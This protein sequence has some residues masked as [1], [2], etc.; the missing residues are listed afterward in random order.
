VNFNFPFRF[1]GTVYGVSLIVKK[2]T[3]ETV[4]VPLYKTETLARGIG[5]GA[6]DFCGT[7]PEYAEADCFERAANGTEKGALDFSNAV[8]GSKS[9]GKAEF[10]KA[11]GTEENRGEILN[12]STDLILAEEGIYFY[13]FE[14]YTEGKTFFVKR[15]KGG[16]ADF[17]GGEW[18]LT[19]YDKYP[20]T[21]HPLAGGVIYHIF[22]DRFKKGKTDGKTDG[23]ADELISEKTDENIKRLQSGGTDKNTEVLRNGEVNGNAERLRNGGTDKNAEVLRNGEVNGN[24]EGLQSGEI[25]YE[26]AEFREKNGV[27]TAKKVIDS[28]RIMKEWDDLPAVADPDGVFRAN[29]FFGGNAE[30]VVE[31]LDYIASLGVNVVY[32][33]PIFEAASNHRYDT[34]DYFKIDPLFGD[35]AALKKLVAEAEKR[36]MIVMMD[37]VFNHTGSDSVYFNKEG[38]YD[39]VGAYQSRDSEYYDFYEFTKFPDKYRAW[40]GIEVVPALNKA[41]PKVR[42]LVRAAVRKWISFGIK[43]L[44]LDV[45]DELPKDYIFDIARLVKTLAPDAYLLG[46]VW[47]DA[48]TKVSYGTMRPY[49]LGSQLDSVMNYP[50]KEAILSFVKHNDKERLV[51]TVMSILENYPAYSASLLMN[52]IDTHDTVRALNFFLE[53]DFSG[54]TK[55]EKRELLAEYKKA[56]VCARGEGAAGDKVFE[57]SDGNADSASDK[58]FE[59]SDGNADSAYGKKSRKDIAKSDSECAE[60]FE[61]NACNFEND[62]RDPSAISPAEIAEAVKKL[63]IA[64]LIQFTLPG[65]PSI[66]Y[67][68]EVGLLG[69]ED[70]LNRAPYP[71]GY[72]NFEL[73]EFYRTLGGFRK[74]FKSRLAGEKRDNGD[75]ENNRKDIDKESKTNDNN[76][77]GGKDSESQNNGKNYNDTDNYNAPNIRFIDDPHLLIYKIAEETAEV[78]INNSKKPRNFKI[79]TDCFDF[80]S[81]KRFKNGENIEIKQSEYLLLITNA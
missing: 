46:E 9:G 32:L 68:G 14:V 6:L 22:A 69:F 33:S 24:A 25:S 31:R 80:L 1:G 76:G 49:L 60:N 18:Q 81:G 51:E 55:A 66:Y 43:G 59:N 10:L 30:G 57:N 62:T 38:H 45:A 17:S 19:V 12:Y 41:N 2:Y 72:E 54:F 36:G 58:V 79:P 40:W 73:L 47:E 16:R 48:S 34:G 37:G 44:R 35:E 71:Y 8:S 65:I 28:K 15:G 56:A 11:A 3:G 20:E 42:K 21:P 78:V 64:A 63:K 67:G 61:N 53:R 77:G 74:E 52:I 13:S 70:P 75:T 23:N 29:D 27:Y 7:D 50:F 5:K 39:S 26:S 4:N